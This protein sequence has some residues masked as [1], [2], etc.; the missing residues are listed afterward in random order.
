MS[1]GIE[2]L[3][4]RDAVSYWQRVVYRAGAAY[5]STYYSFNGE[6]IRE[7]FAT[8]GI[9]LPISAD[10]RLNLGLQ[11][12]IRG[13]TANGLQRDTIVR[14]SLTISGSELW[15]LKFEED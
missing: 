5:N 8:A 4:A 13:T 10:A 7:A 9:G 12:G 2:F 6:T 11:A 3:P 15:F 1:S 14:F